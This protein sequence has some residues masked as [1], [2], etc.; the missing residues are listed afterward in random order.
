MQNET[1]RRKRYDRRVDDDGGRTSKVERRRRSEPQRL[2][3]GGRS[4]DLADQHETRQK[5]NVDAIP[6]S[7]TVT[8]FLGTAVWQVAF[9]K[10][11]LLWHLPLPSAVSASSLNQNPL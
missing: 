4:R 5:Y 7:I 1:P 6:D 8:L 10:Y 3:A 2:V 9:E 11:R